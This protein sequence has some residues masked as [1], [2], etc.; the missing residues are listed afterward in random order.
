MDT[1]EKIKLLENKVYE[2]FEIFNHKLN[3]YNKKVNNILILDGKTNKNGSTFNLNFK[4]TSLTNII[5][6]SILFCVVGFVLYNYK[7]NFI[8][9]KSINLNTHF[10]EKKISF[11]K[12]ILYTIFI[13]ISIIILGILS[14][15]IYRMKT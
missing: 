7:L 12:L 2:N 14:F 1:D 3:M 15:I 6:T 8:Y 10:Y 4:I 13:T 5:I 9:D 11:L